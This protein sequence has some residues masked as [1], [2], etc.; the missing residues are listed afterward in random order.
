MS[1]SIFSP[2]D[3]KVS[4][5]TT[6]ERK[7]DG[8][9]AGR[10]YKDPYLSNTKR[11]ARSV[12]AEECRANARLIAAAPIGYDLADAVLCQNQDGM[13]RS[14]RI[15]ELAQAFAAKIE[16]KAVA[17][18]RKESAMI[19]IDALALTICDEWTSC[20]LDADHLV[21]WWAG[22]RKEVLKAAA[23]NNETLRC[24]VEKVKK[25]R[26]LVKAEGES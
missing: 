25:A 14:G 23:S 15:L 21:E 2:K 3:A 5:V 26:A 9:T 24:A 1:T 10:Q 22:S 20:G 17:I 4:G 8:T 18:I 16:G 19:D 11:Y 7:R 13:D 12:S 6:F